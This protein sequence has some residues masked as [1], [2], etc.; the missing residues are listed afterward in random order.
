MKIGI[1]TFHRSY[2]YG[3]F[4]QA[5]CLCSRLN[6]ENDID[7]EIIDFDT[8]LSFSHYSKSKK[9]IVRM[10]LY[11]QGYRFT[12]T[13]N[14][15]FHRGIDKIRRILSEDRL[16]SDDIEEFCNFVKN[17]YDVIIAGSDEI[18]KLKAFRSFP[19]P[20]FLPGELHARKFSYA[21][22][23]RMDFD[24]LPEEQHKILRDYLN[25][26]EF[27]SVRDRLTYISVSAEGVEK[28]KMM[29]SC[30]PSFLYDF[31]SE[32]INEN[33]LHKKYKLD[34]NKKILILADVNKK[35]CKN[36]IEQLHD[37]YNII[38]TYVRRHGCISAADLDPL[39]WREAIA[40][41]D[42]VITSLFH[43]V[44]FSIANNTPF[45]AVGNKDKKSKLKGLLSGS[46]L[47]NNYLEQSDALDINWKNYL[48]NILKNHDFRP[49][50]LKQRE[51][52]P[53]FLDALRGKNI[54]S[55][56]ENINFSGDA[57]PDT[58][59]VKI[60]DE[61]IRSQSRSGGFFTAVSDYILEND[62]VVYGCILDENYNACHVR[63]TSKSE[64]DLMRGSKYVQSS[65]GNVFNEVKKDLQEDKWVLFSGTPCQVDGLKHFLKKDYEKLVLA[66]I[67]CRGVPGNKVWSKY[68]HWMEHKYGKCTGVVFRNKKDF[69]WNDHI[70]TLYFGSK[71]INSRIYSSM[72]S[73]NFSLRPCCYECKYKCE[74]H[75]SDLTMGD[76][77]AINNVLPSFNDNKGVSLVMIN[78]EKGKN[79][80]NQVRD[81][82]DWHKT[83]YEYSLRD[84]MFSSAKRPQNREQFW[85]DLDK[86]NFSYVA[87]KYGENIR[88][89]NI[90]RKLG[91][92]LKMLRNR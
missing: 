19:N 25:E 34:A 44:C 17:K 79:V 31:K 27:I 23:A 56:L 62:G 8:K 40:S 43:G 38:S 71:K 50:V 18:W 4:L 47:I 26:F 49:F 9:D 51:N 77:W 42:L 16:L 75:P 73:R 67:L 87:G 20:Y 7:A 92:F 57:H 21:A 63:A 5:V 13:R 55:V 29:I 65:L 54:K 22:S 2:N 39:E 37:E 74:W 89:R 80:F 82:L 64:R 83:K 41:A 1:L 14:K 6:E 86:K 76:Y 66:D 36:I 28:G 15:A 88:L 78:S 53:L 12:Q 61:D 81:R 68:L 30:D 70:E 84:T 69:G 32:Q 35:V 3:A 91:K 24:V 10:I 46:D 72:F 52:F 90:K 45:V 33:I 48:E 60:K 85:D 59:A 58:Y 11:P